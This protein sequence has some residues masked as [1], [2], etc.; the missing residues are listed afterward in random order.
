MFRRN[1]ADAEDVQRS[2]D[3]SERRASF[4]AFYFDDPQSAYA[5]SLGQGSLVELELMSP[6]T[7]ERADISGGSEQHVEES[8]FEQCHR[9]HTFYR[10]Q[11]SLTIAD[12]LHRLSD[13]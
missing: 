6:L 12:P 9:S 10:C 13:V 3:K 11:R 4:A 7:N 1:E 5:D 2:Q 8:E